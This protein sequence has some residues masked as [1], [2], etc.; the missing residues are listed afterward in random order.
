MKSSWMIAV[1]LATTLM[2]GCAKTAPPMPSSDEARLRMIA[3]AARRDA[4]AAE[5]DGDTAAAAVDRYRTRASRPA[6]SASPRQL[7]DSIDSGE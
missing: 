4:D 2:L 3:E 6:G 5:M 1:A 7:L